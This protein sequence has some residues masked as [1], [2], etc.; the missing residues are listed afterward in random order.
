MSKKHKGAPVNHAIKY[1][2]IALAGTRCMYCG[3]D[4]GN[5]I[6]WHHLKP[7]YAGGTDTIENSSLL[8]E[9]CHRVIHHHQWGSEEYTRLTKVI[10]L[11]RSEY[12]GQKDLEFPFD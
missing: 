7:R 12:T 5:K 1:Q 6:T 8:C 9:I 10:L 3:K 4:V 2:L 11:K